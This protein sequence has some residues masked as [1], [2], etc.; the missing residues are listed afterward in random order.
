[1][2]RNNEMKSLTKLQTNAQIKALGNLNENENATLFP[3]PPLWLILFGPKCGR[4]GG[5]WAQILLDVCQTEVQGARNSSHCT[6]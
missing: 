2:L 1:M 5:S 4:N 6:W 3:K